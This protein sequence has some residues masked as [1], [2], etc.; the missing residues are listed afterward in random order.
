MVAHA[1]LLEL[2]N[3]SLYSAELPAAGGGAEATDIQ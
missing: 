3:C 2:C 1:L